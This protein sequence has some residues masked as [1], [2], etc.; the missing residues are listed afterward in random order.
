VTIE[1][2]GERL[3][4][5][6]F[7]DPHI[8]YPQTQVIAS[9]GAQLIEWLDRFTF[10]AEAAYGDPEFAAAQAR[11]FINEMLRNGTTTAAVF[12]SVHPESAD[13]FFTESERRNTRMIAGKVM[14]DQNAPAELCDD[15]ERSYDESAA[16]ARRWHGR[17]R[18]LYAITPRFALTS[19]DAQL[20]AA[21]ALRRDFPE[22]YVQTH[23]AENHQEIAAVRRLFPD[24]ASYAAVYRRHGLL[25]QRS[26]LGHCLHL[27]ASE[28]RDLA[29]TRAVAVFCPTSNLFLGSG[30]FDLARLRGA[31]VR[32]GIATDVGGGT[33][34][35]MLRTA[36][37]AYKVLQLQ[38]QNW[39]ALAAFYAITRGNAAVL[40]LDQTIGSIAP[41]Y[42]ADL[43]VLD[44]AATPAMR[45]RF[46]AIRGDDS[47]L[48]QLAAELFLLMTLGD[49]RAV[50][51]VYVAGEPQS[52]EIR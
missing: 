29:E 51:A 48:E 9:Y 3:I 6:G 47:E 33:S 2:H 38:R 17:G 46:L 10:P 49:D 20:A 16:L 5:P 50:R 43:V 26:L 1:D 32:I 44:P 13:A 42:E 12:C 34:Y 35:S 40:G 18:Q 39:P 28:L 23:L 24:D 19:S 30:L 15:P 11:F 22:A 14:M 4:L 31:G 37:E 27:S 52:T 41:G 21:G 36:G 25:G 8:H 7:I 45:H